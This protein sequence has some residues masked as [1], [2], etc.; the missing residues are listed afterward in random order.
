[1]A[2]LAISASVGAPP[3]QN[4]P[5][6]VRSVQ[7]L[8]QNVDPPLRTRVGISGRA[9]PSTLQAIREFQ[10]RF[11]AHPDGRVDPDGPS[12]RTLLHLNDGFASNYVGCNAHQRRIIDSDLIKTQWWLDVVNQKLAIRT[13]AV[14]NA[15]IMNIF[16]I[17]RQW[18]GHSADVITLVNNFMRLRLSFDARLTFEAHP[19][20]SVNIAWVDLNQPLVVNFAANYFEERVQD[21]RVAKLIHE[22]A[23]SALRVLH[24]G[25]PGGGQVNFGEA[26]DDPKGFTIADALNNAYCYEWLAVAVQPGYRPDP[27]R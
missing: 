24:A 6:D 19:D 21:R 23:H 5:N 15:K 17:R 10:S 2:E 25:M 27:W 12:G 13:D 11:M 14:V 16:S 9:D 3:S 4:R 26:P 20:R 1:M 18:A 22:R 7:G 8:L